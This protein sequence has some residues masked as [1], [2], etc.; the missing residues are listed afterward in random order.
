MYPPTTLASMKISAQHFEFEWKNL[1]KARKL[2]NGVFL[3]R[4]GLGLF[5]EFS[6]MTCR[7][8]SSL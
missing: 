1:L 2:W 3:G 8:L 7:I 4:F 6:V 5:I